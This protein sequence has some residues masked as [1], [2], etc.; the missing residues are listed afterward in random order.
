MLRLKPLTMQHMFFGA[1]FMRVL[2]RGF[3]WS[4]VLILLREI[5]LNGLNGMLI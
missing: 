3:V 1:I 4:A 2:C 5:E